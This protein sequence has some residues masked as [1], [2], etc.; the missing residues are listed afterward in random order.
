MVGYIHRRLLK[1]DFVSKTFFCEYID[2][3]Y[4]GKKNKKSFLGPH[5]LKFRLVKHSIRPLD[6]IVLTNVL[7]YRRSIDDIAFKTNAMD[8]GQWGP[9]ES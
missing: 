3:M 6:F 9:Q 8:F 5:C 2:E 7:S 1:D 4:N